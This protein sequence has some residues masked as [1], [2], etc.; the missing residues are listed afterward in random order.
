MLPSPVQFC[1]LRICNRARASLCTVPGL[2][3]VQ[4]DSGLASAPDSRRRLQAHLSKPLLLGTDI[5]IHFGR[6]CA[7]D[8]SIAD[9][10][11]DDSTDNL[12]GEPHPS[13]RGVR[14]ARRIVVKACS[15]VKSRCNAQTWALPN[16]SAQGLCRRAL[17]FTL[18]LGIFLTEVQRLTLHLCCCGSGHAVRG[19]ISTN[20]PLWT[21]LQAA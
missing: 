8:L 12:Y 1:L 5:C 16:V 17:S 11:L 19:R 2:Q 21:S 6:G 18:V 10:F 7:G 20:E 13:R 14:H 15:R 3:T 4:S 9:K